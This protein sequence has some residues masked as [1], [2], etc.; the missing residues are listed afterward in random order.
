MMG[1]GGDILQN[2]QVIKSFFNALFSTFQHLLKNP[3]FNEHYFQSIFDNLSMD[4]LI[5]L[6]I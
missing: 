4:E 3:F 2:F 6:D 5:M 1:G